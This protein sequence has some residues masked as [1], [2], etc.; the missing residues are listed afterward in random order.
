M[1][2][3]W[4]HSTGHF[5]VLFCFLS[6]LSIF[7]EASSK[8]GLF[9][10][11]QQMK[12]CCVLNPCKRQKKKK[13]TKRAFLVYRYRQATYTPILAALLLWRHRSV[14]WH[15]TWNRNAAQLKDKNG[16]EHDVAENENE[17]KGRS[18]MTDSSSDFRNACKEKGRFKPQTGH[19]IR[20]DKRSYIA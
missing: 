17:P 20:A 1:T 15:E 4:N 5:F 10:D 9:H 13:N 19:L 16:R 8:L 18:F 7:I 14:S 12:V 3:L 2:S 11:K 6:L